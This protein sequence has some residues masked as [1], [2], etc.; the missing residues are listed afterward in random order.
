MDVS[1]VL[2]YLDRVGAGLTGDKLACFRQEIE[3]LGSVTNDKNVDIVSREF[4]KIVDR[5]IASVSFR[6]KLKEF[7]NSA[8]SKFSGKD[9]PKTQVIEPGESYVRQFG[10]SG[11]ER[12]VPVAIHK[13]PPSFFYSLPDE[14]GPS[15]D[16]F[17]QEPKKR[18]YEQ[19]QPSSSSSGFLIVVLLFSQFSNQAS[20]FRQHKRIFQL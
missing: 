16:P 10:L 5:S 15:Y 11:R 9:I 1:N 13:P 17:A 2:K 3:L 14:K 4:S 7:F 18:K 6:D 12:N 8:V 20:P 19:T